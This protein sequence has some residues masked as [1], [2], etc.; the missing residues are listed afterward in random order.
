LVD[1]ADARRLHSA[2]ILYAP[3]Y[4]INAGGVLQLLGLEDL[5]WDSQTLEQHLQAIGAT[6]G[7]IYAHADAAGISTDQAAEQLAAS[8]L[9]GPSS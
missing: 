1:P 9:P 8:R 6:L 3:D 4:V 5:G 2:G 7:E